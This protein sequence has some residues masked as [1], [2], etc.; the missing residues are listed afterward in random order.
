MCKGPG[1]LLS[2][3]FG[4]FVAAARRVWLEM[5]GREQWRG[6]WGPDS[7]GLFQAMVCR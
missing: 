7:S 6:R 2:K 1:V 3:G 5:G 4:V